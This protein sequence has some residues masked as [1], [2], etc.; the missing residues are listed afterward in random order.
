ML[1]VDLGGHLVL[2]VGPLTI[3][4]AGMP[5]PPVRDAAGEE[6][7]ERALFDKVRFCTG[8]E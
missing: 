6:L 5:D 8:V 4:I 3:T 7:A 2:T 1:R